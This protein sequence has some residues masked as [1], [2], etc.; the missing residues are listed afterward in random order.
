MLLPHLKFE[1]FDMTETDSPKCIFSKYSVSR[2]PDLFL[3]FALIN[4]HITF[5]SQLPGKQIFNAPAVQT[6]TDKWSNQ[7]SIALLVEEF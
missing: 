4:L 5:L 6:I 7:I 1:R 3:R 2:I